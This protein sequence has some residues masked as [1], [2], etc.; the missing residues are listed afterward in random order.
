[1]KRSTILNWVSKFLIDNNIDGQL[2]EL[3][4]P[5]QMRSQGYLKNPRS[6]FISGVSDVAALRRFLSSKELMYKLIEYHTIEDIKTSTFI[7]RESSDLTNNWRGRI[8]RQGID[9]DLNIPQNEFEK[10]FLYSY[11]RLIITRADNNFFSKQNVTPVFYYPGDSTG[12]HEFFDGG[13]KNF[14]DFLS[15]A[16]TNPHPQNRVIDPLYDYVILFAVEKG[17]NPYNIIYPYSNALPNL[18][19]RKLRLKEFLE[20]YNSDP[21]GFVQTIINKYKSNWN[22][23]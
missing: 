20:K 10:K 21:E 14:V 12:G 7:D 13:I 1:M 15:K 9:F 17:G 19:D 22:L 6:I 3:F 18:D 11:W 2:I 16:S 5:E 8:L 4:I 23:A